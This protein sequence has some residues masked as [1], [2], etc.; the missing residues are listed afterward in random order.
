[1]LTLGMGAIV[2]R[3]CDK[4]VSLQLGDTSLSTIR[5]IGAIACAAAMLLSVPVDACTRFIY[6]TGTDTFIVGRSMD[7]AEDPG[8]DIW[9]FPRAMVRDGA[10]ARVPS[11]GRPNT[12]R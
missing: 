12:A 2:N 1:M 7:W 3:H 10:S 11:S 6:R 8:T 9:S 4:L 5:R